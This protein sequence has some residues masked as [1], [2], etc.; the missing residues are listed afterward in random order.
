M[1]LLLNDLLVIDEATSQNDNIHEL[2]I[3]HS[4][5]SNPI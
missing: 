1:Q 5:L 3:W 4:V 2:A